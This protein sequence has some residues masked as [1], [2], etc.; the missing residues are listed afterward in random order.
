M[1]VRYAVATGNWSD[2]ATWDGGTLPTSTDD[3]FANGFTVTIDVDVEVL[4]IKT[5]AQSPAIAGGGFT[6]ST[7]RIITCTADVGL[8][9]GST[10]CLIITT[11]SPG[12][13]NLNANI[14]TS[15]TTSNVTTLSVTGSCTL[16]ILGDVKGSTG[17]VGGTRSIVASGGGTINIVGNVITQGTAKITMLVNN[18]TVNITGNVGV[19]NSLLN[20][21]ITIDATNCTINIT[22]NVFRN[23]KIGSVLSPAINLLAAGVLNVTGNIE[24]DQENTA[25]GNTYVIQSSALVTISCVGIIA[26]GYSAQAIFS[27]NQSSL[28]FFSGPFVCGPYGVFPLNI[29]KMNMIP[30]LGSYFEFRDNS[31]N[32]AAAPLTPA[33]ATRLVSPDTVVDAPIPSDVRDGVSYALNTF[34]G[35]LKVPNSSSVA[36]G[37]PVDNTT[38]VALLTGDSWITAISSSNDPFAER[39]RNTATVQTTAAQIAAF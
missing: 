12:V 29:Y 31:T 4:S 33:P 37:V 13:V 32:G 15:I 10:T 18:T 34:T 39:L 24:A 36:F 21:T 14:E 22:G 23:N 35:T 16:N 26:A 5:T 6:C 27:S 11:A 2:T 38:G 7:S 30:T 3:V 1:A 28:N 19:S 9:S 20:N 25:L 8:Q 17:N